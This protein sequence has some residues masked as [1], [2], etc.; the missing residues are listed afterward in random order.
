MAHN[1]HFWIHIEQPRK[2]KTAERVGK[3]SDVEH[4][5]ER[6]KGAQRIHI[7]QPRK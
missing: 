3:K 7:E 4:N 2:Q 6:R 5:W 1:G